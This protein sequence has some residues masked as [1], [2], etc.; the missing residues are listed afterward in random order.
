MLV[1]E[2]NVIFKNKI[3]LEQLQLA[4]GLI[5]KHTN[6]AQMAPNGLVLKEGDVMSVLETVCPFTSDPF[7]TQ[8]SFLTQSRKKNKGKTER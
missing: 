5:H 1:F 2:L 3:L 7:L 4:E 8:L 6:T